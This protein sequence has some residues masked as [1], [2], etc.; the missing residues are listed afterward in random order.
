ML[1]ALAQQEIKVEGG[2]I[3]VV[4]ADAASAEIDWLH[5]ATL[6][7][8]RALGLPA[9]A[10]KDISGP[11]YNRSTGQTVNFPMRLKPAAGASSPFYI[12]NFVDLNATTALGD[13]ACGQRTYDGHTGIDFGIG[14]FSWWR[15]DASE[16]E[17]VASAPGTIVNK[18]DGQNDRTC[19]TLTTLPSIPANFVAV[20]QDDGAT[21]YYLHMKTGSP[22]TKAIGERV[23]TGEKLGV[24]GS[25]GRSTGPHL[26]FELRDEVGVAIDPFA[27][28]CGATR[29]LWK[30]QWNAERDFKVVQVATLAATPT[31]ASN[32]PANV[33]L[34]TDTPSFQ[35]QFAPGQTLRVATFVRDQDVGQTATIQL[36]DPNGT[37]IFNFNTGTVNSLS[38]AAYWYATFTLPAT[39]PTG[40]WRARSSSG[41]GNV[42][43]HT[44]FVNSSPVQTSI[45]S[46]ILPGGRSVQTSNTATIFATILNASATTA[47]GCTIQPETPLSAGFSFQTTNPATNAL[48]GTPDTAVDIPGNAAQSFVVAITPSPIARIAEAVTVTLRMKCANADAAPVFEG[49]NTLLLSMDSNPVP[50]VIPIAA[51]VSNDGTVHVPGA[52]GAAFFAAA[53]VNIG[54][55]A[56]LTV[57][58]EVT[59]SPPISV[60]LCETNATTGACLAGPTPSV[61]TSFAPQAVHTFSAFVQANGNVPF[62]PAGTRIRLSFTDAGGIVRGQTSVAVTTD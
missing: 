5:G 49:V 45:V 29:S 43:D 31:F 22:T 52:S 8:V 60:T 53:S 61:A 17:I 56:T 48:T 20:Q 26:H 21:A 16:V 46:A 15:M 58:P 12:S 44:F 55:G 9:R 39:A 33:Q 47:R 14:V 34:D 35:N 32:C 2:P 40:A 41:P 50:D 27:G 3:A 23:V 7:N 19:G 30:H 10:A 38:R 6:S 62:N 59:G 24:V 54:A 42:V 57:A 1:P 25:S 18:R 4:P 37:Q 51:T 11:L 28:T 13:F 36:F